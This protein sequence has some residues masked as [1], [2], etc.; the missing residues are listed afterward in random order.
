[1][2]KDASAADSDTIMSV[3]NWG[4][5]YYTLVKHI[6][7]AKPDTLLRELLERVPISLVGVTQGDVERAGRLKAQYNLPYAEA[8]AAAITTAQHVLVT[9]DTEHFQRV[10]KLRLL[11]LSRA[12][13]GKI[14]N[15]Q[16][17]TSS[18]RSLLFPKTQSLLPDIGKM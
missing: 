2:L 18:E 14:E 9:A 15:S 4:D 17:A 5:V 12:G 6:G 16:E 11:K 1:M 8:F 10:P 3:V 7:R 13:M